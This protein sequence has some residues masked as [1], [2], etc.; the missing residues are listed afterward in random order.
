MG[1]VTRSHLTSSMHGFNK[2]GGTTT[3]TGTHLAGA[4]HTGV[5]PSPR[6]TATV[7]FTVLLEIIGVGLP[8]DS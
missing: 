6:G 1:C 5:A 3:M 2:G 8:P 7:A 4:L